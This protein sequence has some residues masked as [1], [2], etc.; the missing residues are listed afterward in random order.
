MGRWVGGY[1]RMYEWMWVDVKVGVG[2]ISCTP[3]HIL[4]CLFGVTAETEKIG[5]VHTE[6]SQKIVDEI[7][8]SVKEFRTQQK[9]IRKRVGW[10][11]WLLEGQSY[12]V[13]YSVQYVRTYVADRC[14]AGRQLLHYPLDSL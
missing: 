1:V 2:V 12:L 13:K 3:A 4:C 10:S 5:R 8:R 11:A 7:D 6:L 9:E 14:G